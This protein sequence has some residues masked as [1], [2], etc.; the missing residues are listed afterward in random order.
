[1]KDDLLYLRHILEAIDRIRAY[2]TGGSD[3]FRG[4]LKTEDAVVRNLQI[5]GEA[6]KKVSEETRT[7]HPDVPWREMTGMRDRVAHDYFGV[8]L[9]IVWDVVQNH[10]PPLREKV[11]RALPE[12]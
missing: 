5:I 9:D 3:A 11:L 1:M 7:A 12:G 2:T 8:S 4:D 6:A 10:L